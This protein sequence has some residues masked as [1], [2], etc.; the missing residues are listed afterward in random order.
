MRR[1]R[2]MLALASALAVGVIG[3]ASAQAAVPGN[4]SVSVAQ[5]KPFLLQSSGLIIDKSSV[6]DDSVISICTTCLHNKR[7]PFAVTFYG[8]SYSQ[9]QVSANGNLQ[10]GPP[11]SG[12]GAFTNQSLPTTTFTDPTLAVFWDDLFFNPPDTSHPFREGVYTHRSGTAPHKKFIISWQG[13]AFSTESYLVLAQVVFTQ[14]SQT[15][16]MHYGQPDNQSCCAPSETIGSQFNG[17]GTHFSQ[18]TFN[19]PPPGMVRNGTQITLTHH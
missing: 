1:V 5:G 13:H 3:A 10:F 11:G 19:P 2:L 14:G 15:I 4:Y 8:H 17:F 18:Y 7:M 6:T 12:T 16:V 9:I